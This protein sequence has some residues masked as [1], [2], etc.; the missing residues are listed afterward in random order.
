MATT[1]PVGLDQA[2]DTAF[3]A[4]VDQHKAADSSPAPEASA[5]DASEAET[6]SQQQPE[7]EEKAPPQATESADEPQ[8]LTPE[9]SNLT[10]R[11]REKALNAAWTQKTQQLAEQ[12]KQ[13][14]EAQRIYEAIQQDP[15]GTIAQ[16]AQELGL[17]VAAE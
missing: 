15:Q 12:R 4:A 2:F 16:L 9:Q 8:L 14:A 1:A 5:P 3:D 11:A 17:T 6:P 10:G 7:P 13:L